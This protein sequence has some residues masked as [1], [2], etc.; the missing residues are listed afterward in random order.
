MTHQIYRQKAFIFLVQKCSQSRHLARRTGK[1]NAFSSFQVV[2]HRSITLFCVGLNIFGTSQY[3]KLLK[4]INA[5]MSYI[6]RRKLLRAIDNA[7][8]AKHT[9]R[10][11]RKYAAGRTV[12]P[13][14]HIAISHCPNGVRIRFVRSF[15]SRAN[16]LATLA[17]DAAVLI[18]VRKHEALLGKLHSDTRSRA[19]ILTRRT[20]RAK[21]FPANHLCTAFCDFS[22]ACISQACESSM[23]LPNR[24]HALP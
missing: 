24:S 20:T 7:S 15:C 3:R 11:R 12:P 6:Q 19:Y 8:T 23:K 2:L 5:R 13:L 14:L 16:R 10:Q 22:R 9:S 21:V 17:M 4:A 1:Q 18:N